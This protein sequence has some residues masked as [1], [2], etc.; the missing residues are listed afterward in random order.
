MVKSKKK[1][2]VFGKKYKSSNFVNDLKLATN[3]FFLLKDF[4]K[5]ALLNSKILVAFIC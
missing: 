2:M 3:D 1:A 4:N 5:S